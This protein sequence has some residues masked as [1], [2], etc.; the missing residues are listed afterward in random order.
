[1]YLR[2]DKSIVCTLIKIILIAILCMYILFL[3]GTDITQKT[4]SLLVVCSSA[5]SV[6]Y[7]LLNKNIVNGGLFFVVY[8]YTLFVH[9]G[10]V[11]AYF[12]E[13]SYATFQS[14]TS[15]AFLKNAFYSKAI[16]LSNLVIIVFILS[17]N[18]ITKYDLRKADLS[19][20]ID[21]PYDGDKVAD[22][23]CIPVLFLCTAYIGA[24]SIIYNLMF[25]RYS[26]VLSV[27]ENMGLYHHVTVILALTV[28]LLFSVGTDKGIKIGLS[29]F[30]VTTFI[31]FSIGNRGEALYSAAVCLALY[32]LRYRKISKKI[33]GLIVAAAVILIPLVRIV[34]SGQFD[35]YTFNPLN[36]LLETLAELGIQISPVTYIVDYVQNEHGHV[37]G[38]TYLNDFMIFIQNH[39]FISNPL[40]VTANNIKQIMPYDGMGFSMIGE[41]YYNFTIVGAVLFY[42]VYGL[43]L[44]TLDKKIMENG[45]TLT[46]R[47]IYS[48]LMVEFVNLTRNDASTL[49]LY[50]AYTIVLLVAYKMGSSLRNRKSYSSLG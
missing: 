34:R 16:V 18:L 42:I 26:Y 10:F 21:I 31:H 1:M 24:I 17:S 38:L 41:L 20:C 7:L 14:V 13:E 47:I 50:I 4:I 27:T 37:W 29:I 2:R 28:A 39:L 30:I 46:K 25:A 12:F 36:S 3:T 19:N 44:R 49:P 8:L 40:N 32:Q 43:F 35:I 48:L 22:Y 45:L 15:M 11:I 9:N 5:L 6:L 23:I 33:M